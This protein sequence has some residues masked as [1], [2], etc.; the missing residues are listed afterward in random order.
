MCRDVTTL[1]SRCPGPI[2]AS[3]VT[4]LGFAERRGGHE[5]EGTT[6]L[7]SGTLTSGQ[8]RVYL[9]D[10]EVSQ[11]GRACPEIRYRGLHLFLCQ[12]SIHQMFGSLGSGNLSGARADAGGHDALERRRCQDSE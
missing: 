4:V 11:S 12:A 2:R 9:E 5:N 8:Q 6:V 3:F 10:S 7:G 1:A